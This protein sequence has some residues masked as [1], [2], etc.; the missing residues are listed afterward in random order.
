MTSRSN[1][2]V[3]FKSVLLILT[4]ILSR[5]VLCIPSAFQP[6]YQAG[7]NLTHILPEMHILCVSGSQQ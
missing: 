5:D 4:R 6:Y 2:K 1:Q 3:S 7:A